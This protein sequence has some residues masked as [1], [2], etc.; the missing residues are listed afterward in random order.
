MPD[1]HPVEKTKELAAEVDEGR[2]ERTPFLAL[3]GVTVI[4]GIAVGVVLA[5]ALILYFTL[6]GGQNH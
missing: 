2:S 6:G 1:P 3:G 4:V 5:V